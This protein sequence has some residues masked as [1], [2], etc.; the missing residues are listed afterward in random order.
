MQRDRGRKIL[1]IDD[2]ALSRQ[3]AQ[4]A[5]EE[6]GFDVRE[7]ATIKEFDRILLGWAPDMILTDVD[8][9]EMTGGELCRFYKSRLPKFVPVILFSSLSEEEL[10]PL[11]RACGADG[12]LSKR[13]GLQRLAQQIEE[14]WESILW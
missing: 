6:A 9:P 11:A 13:Q 5:L 7:V 8:M 12:F 2:S 4:A 10:A 3:V 14:L 1:L